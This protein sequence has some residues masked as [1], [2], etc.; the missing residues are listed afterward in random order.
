MEKYFYHGELSDK[1][2]ELITLVVLTTN[3]TLDQL[4]A[5]VF[6]ALNIGVTPVAIKEAIYQCVPYLGFQKH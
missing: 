4:Q 3:Q 6:A 2:R 5:H 1:L